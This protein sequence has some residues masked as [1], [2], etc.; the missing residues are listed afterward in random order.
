MLWVALT[1]MCPQ[2][3]LVAS[4]AHTGT[5][6]SINYS[7]P[8]AL[9]LVSD[10]TLTDLKKSADNKSDP[11]RDHTEST[12]ADSFRRPALPVVD[13]SGTVARAAPSTRPASLTAGPHLG[14]G[15]PAHA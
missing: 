12:P 15:P 14:R 6:P 5:S 1:L 8:Q 11:L 4:A 9:P 2:I 3:P 10:F 13:Q 7:Q